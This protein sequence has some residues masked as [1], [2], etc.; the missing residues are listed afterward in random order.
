[1]K[2]LIYGLKNLSGHNLHGNLTVFHRG[3]GHKKKYRLLDFNRKLMNIKGF[4]K[5]IEYDPNRSAN[6]S[7]ISYV[8][9][10][11]SYI[12]TP[13]N[14]KIGDIIFTSIN[15][16]DLMVGNHVPLYNLYKGAIIHNLSLLK[17]NKSKLIRSAGVSGIVL[18]DFLDGYKV[19]KLP[20]GELRAFNI[21]NFCTLGTVSNENH[22]NRILGKAGVNR[23][24]NRRPVVRGVAMN[25]IDHPHG[26]G[27]GKTSGGHPKTP[28]GKPTKGGYKTRKKKKVNKYII[29]RRNVNKF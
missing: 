4:I 28:W 22:K 18:N 16:N 7:L 17:H 2:K 6:I 19:I 10:L 26:G 8:N 29:L 20:S 11:L 12:L 3:G 5:T 24:L 14:I 21:N 23:W 1:M 25:P 15:A 9:G 27:E 13:S